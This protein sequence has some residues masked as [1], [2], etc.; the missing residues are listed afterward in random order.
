M[1]SEAETP[2]A[3]EGC[4]PCDFP[5]ASGGEVSHLPVSDLQGV[6]HIEDLE[7]MLSDPITEEGILRPRDYSF[8]SVNAFV[9]HP[10]VTYE[11]LQWAL[12]G[13]ASH[14]SENGRW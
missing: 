1:Q 13:I 10:D 6:A 9:H 14:F 8:P 5:D 3:S 4:S 12:L 2:D 7:K 11:E